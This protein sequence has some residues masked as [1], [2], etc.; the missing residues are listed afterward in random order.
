MAAALLQQLEL[1]FVYRTKAGII[2]QLALQG[3]RGNVH[4][5]VHEPEEAVEPLWIKDDFL[6]P[7]RLNLYGIKIF[8]IRLLKIFYIFFLIMVLYIYIYCSLLAEQPDARLLCFQPCLHPRTTFHCFY[9]L[10]PQH[11]LRLLRRKT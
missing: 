3:N 10:S 1:W 6:S 2:S 11:F 5:C 7:K 4:V 8:D 9:L